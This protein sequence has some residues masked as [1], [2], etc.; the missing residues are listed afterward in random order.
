MRWMANVERGSPEV[1]QKNNQQPTSVA[2]EREQGRGCT[3][4][5][6]QRKGL[7]QLAA[8]V[9]GVDDERRAQIAWKEVAVA[10]RK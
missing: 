10:D 8:E 5:P 7:L 4:R 3:L 9:D 6:P 2:L 1:D